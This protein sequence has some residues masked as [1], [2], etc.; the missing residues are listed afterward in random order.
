VT[1]RSHN[2]GASFLTTIVGAHCMRMFRLSSWLESRGCDKVVNGVADHKMAH[3]TRPVVEIHSGGASKRKRSSSEGTPEFLQGAHDAKRRKGST[4]L[5]SRTPVPESTSTPT[6][7]DGVSEKLEVA[8]DLDRVREGIESQLSLEI[9]MKHDELRLINQELAKC[10]AA[11][12]QLR[13]CHLIPYPTAQGIPE[14]MQHI[15]NGT[16]PAVVQGGNVPQ[17]APAYGVT[18][19]PY[20]RHYAKWLIPDPAFDGVQVDWQRG[21]D[22][23][24][25]GKTVPEGRATR[26]SF[27][28]GSTAASKSRSQRGSSG[29]KLQALSSGYP[30]AKEKA[31]P[32]ILKRAS[33]G[34]MV[35]LVCIDC[36]RDNFSS[37]QGFIN[38]CRIA[39]RRDF[40]SHDEAAQ[41]SGQP[42]EVDEIGGIVGEEKTQSAPNGL[43]HPLIR[44]AP[45]DKEAYSAL[46]SRIKASLELYDQGKLPGVTSIPTSANSTPL[47]SKN[48]KPA[49][50]PSATFVPS[51][52]TPHLSKLMQSRG[53]GGDFAQMVIEA[54]KK[55]DLDEDSDDESEDT[56]G[57]SSASQRPGNG[58]ETPIL[59][60]MRVPSRAGV[61]APFG[62]PASS[63]G[64]DA[65][66][67]R[68]PGLSGISP[69]LTHATPVINTFAAGHRNMGSTRLVNV[70]HHDHADEHRDDVDVDMLHGPSIN[71]LSPNTVA[72]NNAPS[73]VS[74][75]G[76]YDEGDDAE[77]ASSE[78]EAEDS[79]VAEIDIEDDGVE[80][81]VPRTILRNRSGSGSDGMR[82]RKED[83]QVTFVSPVKDSRRTRRT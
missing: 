12:E 80:K 35:K 46:L 33:D 28:D 79:D 48:S 74:D 62:R 30:Q 65:R 20:T 45:T 49:N 27:A 83:K 21:S 82:L 78:E 72:S 5:E 53:F 32:C 75:D 61:S 2:S 59:P 1:D 68:Q 34:Q 19:G 6:A 47:K 26:H 41:A 18:D 76:E 37:T 58:V 51:L 66:H 15:S 39:H 70:E 77:S 3:A 38:H 17:W 23:S 36:N 11:L 43:V 50:T 67:S 25:A 69:R 81:V 56:D 63:K 16:G 60:A 55:V 64:V 71:D 40:K 9:L 13:R 29:Q 44:S 14:S 31:G 7:A 24:R 52:T 22:M 10:Q 54:K 73:L 57:V 42:I 8:V 4:P